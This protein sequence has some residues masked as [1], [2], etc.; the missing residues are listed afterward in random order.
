MIHI[1]LVRMHGTIKAD[2]T[3]TAGRAAS[4]TSATVITDREMPREGRIRKASAPRA[5][6]TVDIPARIFVSYRCE[7]TA[8][9]AAWLSGTLAS[10]YGRDQIFRD[11]DSI[12]PGDDFR[13]A[14]A[15]AAGSCDVLLALIGRRWLAATGQD[16]RRRLDDPG[17][18]V[19]LEIETAL[20][21]H[22]RVVPIL[23]DGVQVPRS[24]ELPASLAALARR[25]AFALSPARLGADTRRLLA[26]LDPV[27]DSRRDGCAGK[28]AAAV[29]RHGPPSRRAAWRRVWRQ[30]LPTPHSQPRH[31]HR[32]PRRWPVATLGAGSAR[33]SSSPAAVPVPPRRLPARTSRS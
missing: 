28:P 17:D 30:L 26:M 15:M 7:D 4:A 3:L 32:R 27:I 10:R 20:S 24:D 13:E 12:P 31:S 2:I 29:T 21:R 22:V 6:I 5:L 33:G 8:Y 14:I 9:L 19:R 1:G 23:A 18:L 25:Q 16:G 11:V